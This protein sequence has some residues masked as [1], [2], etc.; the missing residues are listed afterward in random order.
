MSH[1]FL[2]HGG[3]VNLFHIIC[4]L[5]IFSFFWGGWKMRKKKRERKKSI[6]KM[7][8]LGE[9]PNSSTRDVKNFSNVSSDVPWS[10][11]IS[12]TWK[13]KPLEKFNQ[14][15]RANQNGREST[16]QFRKIK[17]MFI[18]LIKKKWYCTSWDWPY[19]LIF[20]YKNV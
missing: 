7:M 8:L 13:A 12:Q 5:L 2:F 15:L 6:A 11:S 3:R 4:E 14:I 10:M 20:I 19:S 18:E 9:E 17:Y 16:W 1:T